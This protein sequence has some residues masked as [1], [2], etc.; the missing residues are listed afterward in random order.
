MPH[1][2]GMEQPQIRYAKT[3]DG[4]S[5][6]YYAIGHGPSL[7]YMPP[8]PFTHLE[9]EW[10]VDDLREAHEAAARAATFVRYDG[11][12]CGLSDRSTTDFTLDA[13]VSD[14]EAVA[15]TFAPRPFGLVAAEYMA[16]PALAYAVRHPERVAGLVLWLGVGRGEDIFA[17]RMATLMELARND[18][19]YLKESLS[20]T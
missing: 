3:S 4:V 19:E 8:M 13:M 5:I 9:L 14:L 11:R 2:P 17:G 15:D 18:W 20:H 6:A 7:V 1:T 16:I 12:G 10:K